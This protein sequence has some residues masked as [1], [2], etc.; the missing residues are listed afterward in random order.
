MLTVGRRRP[1]PEQYLMVVSTKS[2]KIDAET[3]PTAPLEYLCRWK[4]SGQLCVVHIR[5]FIFGTGSVE[6]FTPSGAG[7][8]LR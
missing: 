5:P 8:V 4:L 7:F 1:F 2:V 6:P 3:F